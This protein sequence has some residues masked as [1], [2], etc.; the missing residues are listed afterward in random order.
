MQQKYTQKIYITHLYKMLCK[1]AIKIMSQ[2]HTTICSEDSL[3][4][5]G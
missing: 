3:D 1:I 2:K 5:D 4:V